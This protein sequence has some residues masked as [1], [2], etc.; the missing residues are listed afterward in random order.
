MYFLLFWRG[1]GEFMSFVTGHLGEILP[2]LLQ[3]DI[4]MLLQR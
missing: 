3:P 1:G 4:D 2:Q